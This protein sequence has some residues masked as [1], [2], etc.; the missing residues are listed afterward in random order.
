MLS[1]LNIHP[2]ATFPVKML[3]EDLNWKRE[4]KF[5]TEHYV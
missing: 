4:G 2:R 5:D 3:S 1:I